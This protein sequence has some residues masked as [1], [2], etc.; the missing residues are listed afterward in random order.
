MQQPESTDNKVQSLFLSSR[1]LA[2]IA[3][4]LLGANLVLM[5]SAGRGPS[6]ALAQVGSY[7]SSNPS[8]AGAS[9]AEAMDRGQPAAPP[10]TV[11]AIRRME[12][13]FSKLESRMASIEGKLNGELKV[14]VVNFPAASEPAK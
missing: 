4:A 9:R 14:R 5:M 1:G 10:T 2:L 11:E 3:V 13:S 12:M 6:A 7:D 8:L